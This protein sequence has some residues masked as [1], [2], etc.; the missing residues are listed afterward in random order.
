MKCSELLERV[1]TELPRLQSEALDAI[2]A[3]DDDEFNTPV[4]G[5]WSVAT[6]VRHLVLS[7][8]PYVDRM[9]VAIES[10]PLAEDSEVRPTFLGKQIL[11]FAGPKG[12]APVPK[13]F[14]PE[15]KRFDRKV[16]GDWESCNAAFVELAALAKGRDLARGRF[17]NPVIQFA[18]MNLCDGFAIVVDHTE[19]HVIQ[20]VDRAKR[21]RER[22]KR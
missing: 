5:Q 8:G 3:L 1:R 2:D 13:P 14:V 7:D 21:I 17:R 16:L 22:S 20:I 4:D 6:V 18:S 9:R 12:N 19:R 10:A 15:S 11:K